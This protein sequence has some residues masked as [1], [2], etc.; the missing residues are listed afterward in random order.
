M[1]IG[2]SLI[3]S[4]NQIFF[5]GRMYREQSAIQ[6]E[7][8]FQ[9]YPG[10]GYRRSANRPQSKNH[11]VGAFDDRHIPDIEELTREGMEVEDDMVEREEEMVDDEEGFGYFSATEDGRREGGAS[12]AFFSQPRRMP[13]DYRHHQSH[14]HQSDQM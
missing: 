12:G 7:R 1:G 5:L 3:F 13:L 11:R 10:G 2:L 4:S 14:R 9:I 6:R 8:F